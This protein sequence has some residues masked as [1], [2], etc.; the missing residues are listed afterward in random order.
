[1]LQVIIKEEDNRSTNASA[2]SFHAKIKTFRASLRGVTDMK[3][4]RVL[5]ID[6]YDDF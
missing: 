1:M 2:E 4:L 5:T 6:I 3:F